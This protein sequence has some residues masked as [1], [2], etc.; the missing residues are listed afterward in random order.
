[1]SIDRQFYSQQGE[2]EY[3]LKHFYPDKENGFFIELG[4]LDGVLY[5]NTKYFEDQ[6]GWTGILIEAAPNLYNSLVQNRPNCEL[7]HY[8]ICETDGEVEFIG[9]NAVG[10]LVRT[11]DEGAQK[12]HQTNQMLPSDEFVYRVPSKPFHKVVDHNRVPRVD[13]LLVDVEGAE[14][15]VLSTY[16]WEIETPLVIYEAPSDINKKSVKACYRFM[17][18]MG[19]TRAPRIRGNEAWYR[20][21]LIEFIP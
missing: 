17:K 8:A 2:D 1:M 13:F 7:H 4:A 16:D 20:K 9:N 3:I 14:F 18:N 10:G 12:R 19:Y 11:Y 6:K 5:S 15:E 21:G